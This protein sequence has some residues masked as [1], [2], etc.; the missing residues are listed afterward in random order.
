MSNNFENAAEAFEAL[1]TY[2]EDPAH[3]VK[4]V[5]MARAAR[6]HYQRQLKEQK[7]AILRMERFGLEDPTRNAHSSEGELARKHRWLK[8]YEKTLEIAEVLSAW[9]TLCEAERS[10]PSSSRP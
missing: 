9:V 2:A 7:D 5:W 6:D 4:F 1:R 3:A 10:A 8:E